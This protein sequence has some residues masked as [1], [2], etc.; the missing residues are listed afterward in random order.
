MVG[1]M[2][3][4]AP[5][6]SVVTNVQQV[7]TKVYTNL[8]VAIVILLAGVILGRLAGRFI[9]KVLSEVGINRFL[10]K[11]T[12]IRLAVDELLANI[13]TYAIYFI[14]I[15]MALDQLG[16]ASVVLKVISVAMIL[17]ILASIFLGIRD[18]FPNIMAGIFIT[19]RRLLRKGDMVR[20]GD[21]EGEIV[22]IN[23][24]ET[25]IRTARNDIIYLPNSLMA[26]REL[27]KLGKP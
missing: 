20:A 2:N 24:V 9:H 25:R 15:M 21:I 3:L 22:E 14:A 16:L 26:K 11:A 17:I 4:T 10:R 7:V 1:I 8:F 12:G 23:L 18:F 19:Q 6:A 13:S 5:N 27:V